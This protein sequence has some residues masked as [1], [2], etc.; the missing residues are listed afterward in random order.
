MNDKSDLDNVDLKE[1]QKCEELQIS[2]MLDYFDYS[3]VVVVNLP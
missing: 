1:L 2:Q 3:L